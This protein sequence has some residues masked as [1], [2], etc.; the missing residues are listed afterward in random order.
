LLLDYDSEVDAFIQ[1]LSSKL[2]FVDRIVECCITGCRQYIGEQDMR[3][4]LA[5]SVRLES[6]AVFEEAKSAFAMSRILGDPTQ[7]T[8]CQ[9]SSFQP[10]ESCGAS[11]IKGRKLQNSHLIYKS[12]SSVQPAAPFNGGQGQPHIIPADNGPVTTSERVAVTDPQPKAVSSN[13][14]ISK[15]VLGKGLNQNPVRLPLGTQ[16][17]QQLAP[18]TETVYNSD[19]QP[20]NVFKDFVDR[21]DL[22]PGQQANWIEQGAFAT[23]RGLSSYEDMVIDNAFGEFDARSMSQSLLS[24]T[25]DEQW[26]LNDSSAYNSWINFGD[27]IGTNQ[28]HQNG[29]ATWVRRSGDNRKANSEE[30]FI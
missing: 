19:V 4:K 26:V 29:T 11:S 28:P 22:M 14:L 21:P 1:F 24:K 30:E 16:P 20:N 10:K 23:S 6:A 9:Q 27:T 3:A 18:S 25:N 17:D 5:E 2:S 7:G 13:A 12:S 15:S 8:G